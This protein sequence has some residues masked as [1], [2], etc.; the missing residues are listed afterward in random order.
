MIQ[1]EAFRCKDITQKLLE[2]SRS[3]ERR[4]EPTDLGELV[5]SVLDV[6]QHLQ[7]RK[8]KHI[9]FEA[10]PKVTAWINAQE[11]KS[12][13][14]NLVVNAL[15]SMEDDGTLTIGLEPRPAWPR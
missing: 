10:H 13:V 4:R 6:T 11:V 9:I 15:D 3:G 2:F 7:T 1:E 8:G 5:Q 14:L 12:V